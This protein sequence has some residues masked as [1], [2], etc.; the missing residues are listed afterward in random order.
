[1]LIEVSEASQTGEARRRAVECAEELEFDESRRG[2]VAIVTSEMASN[3]VK[4][5]GRGSILLQPIHDDRHSMLR[6]M[7]IDHGPGIRD[8]SKALLDGHS[9]AGSL[10]TGLGAVQRLSD[11][12]EIYSGPQVGTV[13]RADFRVRSTRSAKEPT[14]IEVGVVS[15]PVAGE[16]VCGDGWAIRT[17]ADSTLMLV[18]DGLGHGVLANEAA[19]EAKRVLEETRSFEPQRIVLDVHSA[20][21]KTRGAAMAI[22]KLDLR[23][24]VLKFAGVG[25]ISAS[26]VSADSRRGLPSHNGTLGQVASRVQEF[27]Y[28]WNPHD[29]LIMHSDGLATRWDLQQYPGIWSKHPSIIAAILHRDFSRGRDD[30]TVFV[31]RSV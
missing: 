5:A 27:T 8:V 17:T 24:G 22:A 7:A 18:V 3:L 14:C 12:F 10:G 2:A 25:N 23:S 19:Q 21:K 9:S 29:V 15:E 4:H 30:V 20:L 13:V 31:A 1:M 26:I 6:V 28:P 11:S 16:Q